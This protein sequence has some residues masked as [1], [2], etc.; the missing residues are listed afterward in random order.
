[1]RLVVRRVHPS[2]RHMKK[3]TAFEQQTDWCYS[4]M[5]T[6]IR[7][8]W[9]IGGS[10]QI[11]FLDA[12]HRD[13]AEVEDRVRT[14]KAIGLANLPSQSWQINAADARR[15]PRRRSRHL[16]AA[17]PA[18]PGRPR[19][20]RAGHDEPASLSP[21]GL[22]GPPRPPPHPAHRADLPLGGGVHHQLD[23]AHQA[24]GRHLTAGPAPTRTRKEENPQP[25]DP[26]NPA[27]PAA[28][29]DGPSSN[30]RG[31]YGRRAGCPGFFIVIRRGWDCA[32]GPCRARSGERVHAEPSAPPERGRRSEAV[33][34]P[35]DLDS[36]APKNG[37]QGRGTRLAPGPSAL[38][39]RQAG[40]A[41]LRSRRPRGRRPRRPRRTA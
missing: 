22:P 12:L 34:D 21:S 33:D 17:H 30:G 37:R 11:Q 32:G 28:S 23:E 25:P 36:K 20:R 10:R 13:H 4:I 15:E 38:R 24:S 2:R 5:A 14:N 7:H 27:H 1:M 41:R 39:P 29:R 40:T 9:G 26:W 8:V 16:A 6:N 19:R 18:R 35:A 31:H 3:L